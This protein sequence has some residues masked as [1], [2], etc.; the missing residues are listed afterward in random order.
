MLADSKQIQAVINKFDIDTDKL[1][2]LKAKVMTIGDESKYYG[3]SV[4]KHIFEIGSTGIIQSIDE[5]GDIRQ[6]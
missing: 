3:N 1:E 6:T 2:L 5:D 4:I